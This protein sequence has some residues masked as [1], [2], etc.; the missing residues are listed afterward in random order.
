MTIAEDD[1]RVVARAR[2]I[3]E[4]VA[5]VREIEASSGV[6]RDG[7][8]SIRSVLLDLAAH[9]ELFL[10]GVFPPPNPGGPRQSCLY[11]L[12]EDEDH[13]FALYANA[14]LGRYA[15]A[16][17]NHATWAVIVGVY[18]EEHNRLYRRCDDGGIEETGTAVIGPGTGLTFLPDDLHSLD[19]DARTPMLNFHMYGLALE[20][21]SERRYWSSSDRTWRP[22]PARSDIRE[23]RLRA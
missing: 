5:R 14:A 21:L 6:N 10:P 12:S 4:T 3:A 18:G 17:H 23:A 2:A 16:A 7:L 1:S 20:Q 8:A 11:R 9:R 13:R 19:I 15:N 22:F